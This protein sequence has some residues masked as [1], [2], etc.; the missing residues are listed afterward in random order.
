MGKW[1]YLQQQEIINI[2]AH[3]F[4][5]LSASQMKNNY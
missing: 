5:E 3:H 2:F 4:Y 1:N